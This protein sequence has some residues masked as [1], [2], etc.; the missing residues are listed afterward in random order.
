MKTKFCIVGCLLLGGC[1]TASLLPVDVANMQSRVM[2][3]DAKIQDNTQILLTTVKKHKDENIKTNGLEALFEIYGQPSEA[4]KTLGVNLNKSGLCQITSDS[5]TLVDEKKRLVWEIQK[6]NP[7]LMQKFYTYES[8]HASLSTLKT[9]AYPLT[10]L[11]GMLGVT[12]F[13][14]KRK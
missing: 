2:T 1:H 14:F 3:I 11:L 10:L 6:Q 8:S 9:L 13:L 12:F 7:R 5:L 4:E